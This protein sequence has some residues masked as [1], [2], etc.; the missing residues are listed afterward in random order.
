MSPRIHQRSRLWLLLGLLAAVTSWLY[1]HRILNPWEHYYHV[2]AGTMKAA[3][4]DLYSPWTGARSLLLE[5]RNPYGPEVTHEIQMAF[6]GHDVIQQSAPGTPTIDEQRFAYPVYM[7][8]LLAPVVR[9]PFEELEAAAP[10]VLLLAVAGSAW[11]WLSFLRWRPLPAAA[12]AIILFVVASPQISQGF[13]LRQLGMLV[14]L[15]FALAAWLVRKNHL[16]SAGAVL[17]L[18]TIKPQMI[19]LPLAWLFVWMIGDLRKRWRL[20]AGFTT[21]LALLVGAGELILPGWPRDFVG[22]LAAYRKYGPVRTLMQLLL[23][24][25]LGTGIAVI[26][27]ATLLV[28]GWRRRKHGADTAE[29]AGTLSAFLMGASIALS[30]MPP[31]NQVLLILPLFILLRDW[32]HLP[33]TAR[34]VFGVCVGWPWVTSLVMLATPP[35]LNSP[36]PLPLLPSALVLLFPIFLPVMLASRRTAETLRDV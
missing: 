31:F 17:A 11:L 20:A 5:K 14:A 27:L 29:F 16:A 19:V 2:E 18:A 35:Q 9:V 7:I 24:D 26:L 33:S 25:K 12:V 32:S 13:R 28:Y 3:L 34:V 6:Y 15:L 1:V 10:A 8:L 30:L 21:A 22:G 4:G 36:R 23:G